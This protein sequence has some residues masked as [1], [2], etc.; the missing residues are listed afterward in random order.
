MGATCATAT[1]ILVPI[2]F[3]LAL[4][5]LFRHASQLLGSCATIA[6]RNHLALNL[7]LNYSTLVKGKLVGEVTSSITHMGALV[8]TITV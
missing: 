1:L 2:V 6:A 8:S 3:S 4:P 7:I 5:A